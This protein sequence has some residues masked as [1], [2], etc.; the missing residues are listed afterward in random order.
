MHHPLT[1]AMYHQLHG[2]H[3]ICSASSF[4]RAVTGL[5]DEAAR[6]RF[7]SQIK[8]LC[9]AAS[10]VSCQCHLSHLMTTPIPQLHVY[11]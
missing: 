8:A 10:V 9:M 6:L 7:T 11:M 1:G 5:W 3:G 4:C 2:M